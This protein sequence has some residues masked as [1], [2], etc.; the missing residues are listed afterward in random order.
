[1][2]MKN[3]IFQK[4]MVMMLAL[5]IG[6]TSATSVRVAEL[7]TQERGQLTAAPGLRVLGY[8]PIGGERQEMDALVRFQEGEGYSFYPLGEPGKLPA[9]TIPES[10]LEAFLLERT[11]VGKTV[12]A[13][14]V[15]AVLGLAILLIMV[16]ESTPSTT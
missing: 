11:D 14:P 7:D 1:M 3:R 9:I 2:V 8:V 15:V 6:C 10:E 4:W 16:V 12:L 5:L 13:I